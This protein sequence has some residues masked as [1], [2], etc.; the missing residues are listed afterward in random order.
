[1]QPLDVS[2]FNVFKASLR[3]PQTYHA[4]E[5]IRKHSD[6][7]EATHKRIL[8]MAKALVA[9]G[10]ATTPQHIKKGFE[11]TGLYPVCMD[12]FVYYQTMVRGVPE[13]EQERVDKAVDEEIQR[14]LFEHA[15]DPRCPIGSGIDVI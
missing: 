2:I 13:D 6:L 14:D 7:P 8:Q 1:M 3:S 9:Y 11:K 15:E 5:V 4:V 12:H 10:V